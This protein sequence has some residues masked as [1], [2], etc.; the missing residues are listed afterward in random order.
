MQVIEEGG[1]ADLYD[2]LDG[3]LNLIRQIFLE[4]LQYI[5]KSFGPEYQLNT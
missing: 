1:D 3:D 2:D 5:Y 4:Y